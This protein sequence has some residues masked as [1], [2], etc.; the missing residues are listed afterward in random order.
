M[1]KILL[2]GFENFGPHQKNIT[3]YLA[4]SL[5]QKQVG[6][7]LIYGEVL[8]VSYQQIEGRLSNVLEKIQPSMIMATGIARARE[9]I[10]LELVA[11]N[12]LYSTLPDNEGVLKRFEK[13]DNEAPD[14]LFSTLPLKELLYFCEQ[15][16]IPAE[17]SSSAGT[18][19]CNLSMFQFLRWANQQNDALPCGFIHYPADM[20][21]KDILSH[22]TK[23]IEF[24]S[25]FNHNL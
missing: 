20:S 22:T 8:P 9:K 3:E 10:S 6:D 5:D 4:K 2:T 15:N 1:R 11:L 24:L 7:C 25:S 16:N 19:L 23:I 18:Y 14:A 17:L 21:E 13:I 12:Y